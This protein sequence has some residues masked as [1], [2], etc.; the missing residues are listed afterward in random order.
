MAMTDLHCLIDLRWLNVWNVLT[1]DEQ[2]VRLLVLLC[3]CVCFEIEVCLKELF[4]GVCVRYEV[5]YNL[6]RM[7]YFAVQINNTL[8][9]Q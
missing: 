1:L 8:Q 6:N 5:V 7:R 4:T 9:W 2:F 3:V